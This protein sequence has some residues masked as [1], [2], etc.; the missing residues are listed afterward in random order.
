MPEP[1]R[2]LTSSPSQ[3]VSADTRSLSHSLPQSLTPSVT[4]S[5]SH[6]RLPDTRLLTKRPPVV[7]SYFPAE[8]DPAPLF[9]ERERV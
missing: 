9:R 2:G 8:S 4:H 7:P 5:L 6:S 1:L 3:R